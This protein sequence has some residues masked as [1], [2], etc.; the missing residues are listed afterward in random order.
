MISLLIVQEGLS[1]FAGMTESYSSLHLA[2]FARAA[3]GTITT[4]LLHHHALQPNKSEP[5]EDY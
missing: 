2:A 4:T 3:I 5:G 1:R